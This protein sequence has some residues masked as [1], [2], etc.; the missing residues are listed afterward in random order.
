M[1]ELAK[2]VLVLALSTAAAVRLL[3]LAL[4]LWPSADQ[5]AY[6]NP[7]PY[8]KVKF[9]RPVNAAKFWVEDFG[10]LTY[11]RVWL[12]VNGRLA[13]SGGPGTDAAA[14]CG[15]EVAAVVKLLQRHQE[16]GR[17]YT[18]HRTHKGARRRRDE[19]GH[20]PD[21]SDA[22]LQSHDRRHGPDRPA[23]AVRWFM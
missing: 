16:A 10:G 5:L 9:D 12:Y 13:A 8:L 14:K 6:G 7:L 15:D 20:P 21:T 1:N 4:R 18:L 3:G 19:T 17:S 23:P 11:E 22:G 2:A